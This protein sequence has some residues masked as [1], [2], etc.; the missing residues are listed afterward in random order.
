MKTAGT[1]GKKKAPAKTR[2]ERKR[3]ASPAVRTYTS[4]EI[5]ESLGPAQGFASGSSPGSSPR[6]RR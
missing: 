4:K 6:R 3:Y 2:K 1:K 5:V